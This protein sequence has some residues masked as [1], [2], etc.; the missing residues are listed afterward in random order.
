MPRQRHL[1]RT[2]QTS[3]GPCAFPML[4][5]RRRVKL[6]LQGPVVGHANAGRCCQMSLVLCC[7][8]LRRSPLQSSVDGH[9]RCPS[10]GKVLRAT[11]LWLA[12]RNSESQPAIAP[13]PANELDLPDHEHPCNSPASFLGEV[14]PY[15]FQLSGEQSV[16]HGKSLCFWEKKS[17]KLT[18]IQKR[19]S[20]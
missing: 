2:T 7:R 17:R 10:Q 20:P 1:W 14:N 4:I 11:V 19:A 3:G 15:S 13:L 16:E 5:A 8:R 6:L 18:N 12:L 9:R